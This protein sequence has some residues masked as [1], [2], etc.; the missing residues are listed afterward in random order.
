MLTTIENNDATDILIPWILYRV[1]FWLLSCA[2]GLEDSRVLMLISLPFSLCFHSV[3]NISTS[4]DSEMI[5]TSLPKIK[6]NDYAVLV[7]H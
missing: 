5:T 7:P 3:E 1:V 6:I 2:F 4:N